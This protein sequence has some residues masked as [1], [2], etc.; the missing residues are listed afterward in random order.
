MDFRSK[1]G[2]GTRKMSIFI[3]VGQ[4]V[5][6]SEVHVKAGFICNLP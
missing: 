6:F 5:K 3:V 4:R 1:Y 2:T